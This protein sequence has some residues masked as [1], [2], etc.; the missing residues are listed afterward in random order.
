MSPLYVYGFVRPGHPVPALTQG[1]GNP[2]ARVRVVGDGTLAA[3]VS[4]AP[5]D[6]LARRRDLAAHREV[7][8][9]LAADGPVL[10]MRFGV[11]APD[12]ATLRERLAE[13]PETHLRTLGRLDGRLEMNCKVFPVEAALAGLLRADA[14]LRA[15]R[16][17]ARRRPGYETS[18]R[19]GEAAT[20]ALRR[21]A[22]TAAAGAVRAL[23]A[24]AEAVAPGPEVPGCVGNTSFLVPRAAVADFRTEAARHTAALADRAELRVTGPLPCF[25]FVTPGAAPAVPAAAAMG[26]A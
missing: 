16:D 6:L 11:V 20:D 26:Q 22:T 2:P 19:L 3:A 25:S 5:P 13:S 9:A 23:A 18:V 15:L 24:Y 7:L 4:K 21:H 14:T 1:V 10:P 17:Q 12:R 8:L